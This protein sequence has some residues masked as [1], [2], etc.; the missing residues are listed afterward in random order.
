MEVSTV[1]ESGATPVVGYTISKSYLN[2]YPDEPNTRSNASVLCP[3]NFDD[4]LL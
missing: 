2:D 1:Y 4:V 3:K